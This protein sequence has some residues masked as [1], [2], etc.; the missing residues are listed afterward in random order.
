MTPAVD[1]SAQ[2][3]HS[4]LLHGAFLMVRPNAPSHPLLHS[5]AMVLPPPSDS[6]S[7]RVAQPHRAEPG[8]QL[9]M[10]FLSQTVPAG[11]VPRRP[12][13]PSLPAAPLTP[14]S[15][16]CSVSFSLCLSPSVK[17]DSGLDS[18]SP[19]RRQTQ[20]ATEL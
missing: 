19:S 16:K 15:L 11:L 7:V 14:G 10:N 17:L 3:V 4:L 12:P 8:L 1:P 18:V 6:R 2:S 20:A 5:A 13:C 9:L